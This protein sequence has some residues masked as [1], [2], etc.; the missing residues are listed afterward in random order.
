MTLF[1]KVMPFILGEP[2]KKGIKPGID[3]AVADKATVLIYYLGHS[4]GPGNR[5]KN[6]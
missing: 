6:A 2:P 5:S 3:D 1:P 4:A